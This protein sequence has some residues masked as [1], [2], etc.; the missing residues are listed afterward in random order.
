MGLEPIS[1]TLEWWGERARE[2]SNSPPNGG[3]SA[4]SCSIWNCSPTVDPSSSSPG[5]AAAGPPSPPLAAGERDGVRFP[6]SAD[7]LCAPEPGRDE[8]PL[9]QADRPVL[10]SRATAEGGQ[11]G[12]TGFM[13]RACSGSWNASPT[14]GH[15][16]AAFY[17]FQSPTFDVVGD[18]VQS[19]FSLSH[20]CIFCRHTSQLVP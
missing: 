20:S 8:L 9:V 11:V 6:R 18:P 2:P 10:R 7:A 4:V 13:G 5:P 15:F 3:S 14:G 16:G 12:P 1:L 17:G 19:G